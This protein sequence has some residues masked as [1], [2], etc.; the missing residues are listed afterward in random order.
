MKRRTRQ[1]EKFLSR[2]YVGPHIQRVVVHGE[3]T[4][5]MFYSNYFFFNSE[6]YEDEWNQVKHELRTY[7][8]ELKGWRIV[9]LKRDS[10][11]SFHPWLTNTI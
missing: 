8:L 3:A 7:F 2:R 1:Y 10:A 9:I 11:N 6:S 4:T 5:V